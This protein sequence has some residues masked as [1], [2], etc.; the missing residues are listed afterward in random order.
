[1]NSTIINKFKNFTDYLRSHGKS[2]N[3]IAKI[4]GLHPGNGVNIDS[5]DIDKSDNYF[6]Y[7]TLRNDKCNSVYK[8]FVGIPVLEN[9]IMKYYE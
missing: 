8:N 4:L 7:I 3:D 6:V 1:M 5:Y 2:P 9:I